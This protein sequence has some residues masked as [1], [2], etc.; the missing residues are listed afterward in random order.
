MK[1]FLKKLGDEAERVQ[2]LIED[3]L[4]LNYLEMREN[5]SRL[6]SLDIDRIS[7]KSSTSQKIGLIG[8]NQAI[9]CYSSILVKK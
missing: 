6:I 8:N 4:S 2:T 1:K 5:I 3:L 9:A 7:I